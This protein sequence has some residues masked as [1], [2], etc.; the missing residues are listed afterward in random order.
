MRAKVL[1]SFT[2][3]DFTRVFHNLSY[4]T[5][6]VFVINSRKPNR[7]VDPLTLPNKWL[8]FLDE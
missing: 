8:H 2:A 6:Y 4:G 1:F 5:L 3:K 7:G